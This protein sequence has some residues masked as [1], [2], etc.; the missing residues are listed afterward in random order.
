[1]KTSVLVPPKGEP[2]TLAEVKAFLK[3]RHTQE[4]ELLPHLIAT[5]RQMAETYTRRK[6]MTQ[7]LVSVL[8]FRPNHRKKEGLQRVWTSGDRYALFL[9]RGP[10]QQVIEVERISEE[11]DTVVIP[12]RGYHVNPHHDPALLVVDDKSGWGVRVTYDAGY[13]STAQ[14]SPAPIRQAILQ[15][16]AELYQNRGI[17]ETQLVHGVS[18]LLA[19]YRLPGGVL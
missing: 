19:P 18:P 4:D 17:L 1:M 2:I 6:F 7:R 3:I 11:G 8:P 9:P 5:A 15:M 12:H 16:V 14:D 13:G 10:L